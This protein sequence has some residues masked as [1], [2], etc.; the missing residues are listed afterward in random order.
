MF[1]INSLY[2]SGSYLYSLN[3]YRGTLKL[4]RIGMSPLYTSEGNRIQ[5]G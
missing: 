1:N 2:C 4:G 3:F 5:K